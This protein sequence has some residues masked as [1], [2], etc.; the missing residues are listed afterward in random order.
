M[1]T[2]IA[3]TRTINDPT[4]VAEAIAAAGWKITEVVSG[5][6]SFVDS[7]GEQWG[8]DHR[9]PVARFPAEW[10]RFGKSA[11]LYRNQRMAEYAEAL[12]VI[13]DCE[14]SRTKDM[15]D[16]ARKM[17]LPIYIHRVDAGVSSRS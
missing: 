3:G 8:V 12:I 14:S 16:R 7:I 11:Y 10:R 13:L 5:C 4:I 2:I 6:A 9:V 1:K 17:K 15:I